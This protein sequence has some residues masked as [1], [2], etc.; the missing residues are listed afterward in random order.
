M[1][2]LCQTMRDK[3]KMQGAGQAAKQYATTVY[4]RGN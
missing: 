3:L 1:V 2:E 4:V